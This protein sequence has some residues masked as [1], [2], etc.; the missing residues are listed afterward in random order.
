M[1]RVCFQLQVKPDRLDEYRAR[2]AAV[3]PDMLR[4]LH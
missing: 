2:H 4:A 1:Q 3:W